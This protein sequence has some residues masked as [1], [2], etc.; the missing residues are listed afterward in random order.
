[1][2]A[3]KMD[4]LILVILI[5]LLLLKIGG[6][7]KNLSKL[8]V[9]ILLFHLNSVLKPKEYK[10]EIE[11]L[12]VDFKGICNNS[13][14]IILYGNFTNILISTDTGATWQQKSILGLNNEINKINVCQDEF[15]GIIDSSI[16]IMSKDGLNW[17]II[18]NSFNQKIIDI[19]CDTR[20][21]YLLSETKNK[22]YILDKNFIL[23]DSISFNMH[24]TEMISYGDKIFIG[25]SDGKLLLLFWENV[26][27]KTN[28]IDLYAYGDEIRKF[29]IDNGNLYFLV[30]NN[31]CFINI[32]DPNPKFYAKLNS[33]DYAINDGKLVKLKPMITTIL[34]FPFKWIG[35]Y[36]YDGNNFNKVNFDYPDRFIEDNN[37]FL[38]GELIYKFISKNTILAVGS[39]KTILMSR[40]GGLNW[41]IV[42]FFPVASDASLLILNNHH[43]AYLSRTVFHSSNFGATWLPQ[44][45]DSS[46]IKRLSSITKVAFLFFDTT[47][48]G[49][50]INSLDYTNSDSTKN[51]K[52]MFSNDFGEN[53]FR[54]QNSRLETLASASVPLK[55]DFLRF[56]NFYILYGLNLQN[57]LIKGKNPKSFLEFYDSSFYSKGFRVFN[58]TILYKIK[59]SYTGDTLFG[60]FY[61]GTF[62]E[63]DTS[64]INYNLKNLNCWIG[65]SI[66][67]YSWEKLFDLNINEVYNYIFS[68]PKGFVGWMNRMWDSTLYRSHIF[69]ADLDK[70]TSK[71]FNTKIVT[72]QEI[73]FTN[74]FVFEFLAVLGNNV[75]VSGKLDSNIYVYNLENLDENPVKTSIFD[76]VL[77][78]SEYQLSFFWKQYKDSVLYFGIHP[79]SNKKEILVRMSF[80]EK[81]YSNIDKQHD[82]NTRNNLL[83]QVLPPFPQ[84]TYSQV[85]V[86]IFLEHFCELMPQN[87]KIYD[88]LGNNVITPIS[89]FN[90][91]R[92]SPFFYEI[93]IKLDNFSNGVYFIV[94][95]SKDLAFSFPV[96]VRKN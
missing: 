31:L 82:N 44:K 83:I 5:T 19:A 76:N 67:G 74:N 42:S 13:K 30:D 89:N 27:L 28:I 1:M 96:V 36:Y 29:V 48:K 79:R 47:G 72:N 12:N 84:P 93:N 7:M 85:K 68:V 4:K 57:L 17:S 70:K 61:N 69:F 73:D 65:F 62:Y 55:F 90:L 53:Y 15:W 63:D 77:S 46:Y 58:D 2:N 64:Y 20:F 24:L 54:V 39:N 23:I 86:K 22:V 81:D 59:L 8:L 32:S 60:L 49:F 14:S 16:I 45:F 51:F 56:K 91:E 34:N 71:I 80:I 38:T 35:C 9:L 78:Y 6:N 11:V 37:L 88:Y 41:K 87:F 3:N 95:T 33:Y 94:Y 66:D 52:V 50:Y 92:I 25:T 10:T 18:T 26:T 40:D 43:W 21:I 75:F